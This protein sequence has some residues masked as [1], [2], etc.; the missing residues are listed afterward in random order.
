M[1]F[2]KPKDISQYY[3]F[4]T[5]V[6][7]LTAAAAGIMWTLFFLKQPGAHGWGD[8]LLWAV[9]FTVLL[10]LAVYWQQRLYRRHTRKVL[11]MLDAIENNDTAIHFSETDGTED[12]R[13]VN[14]SL[15]RVAR[16]LHNVK[17][18]TAQ[19]EKYYELILDC[20]NTGIIVL[21]DNGAVYQKNNE[22]LRLLGLEV[23]THVR[24]LSRVDAHLT[25]TLTA[26]RP[27][28]KFQAAFGNE[29]G[30]VNLSVRVSDITVRQEHL[31]IL[32]LN[33]INNELDEKEIDSWIR[34]TRVL[35]HEIMNAV[36][37]ITS[38]SDTLLKLTE[39]RISKEEMRHG[40][41]TIS[42][43]GKGLLAFV[44]SYR[45]FTRIPTPE[46]S[47]F[48]LKG[49]INRMAELARHQYPDTPVTFN[50][51]I[52][53]DD[54]ILYADEN[55]I[56]QVII[57]LLK[58]P[59]RLLKR[60]P[61][62]Q[63]GQMRKQQRKQTQRLRKTHQHTRLLQ[64]SRSRT[65]RNIQQRPCHP[66]GHCRAYFHSFLHHQ[67]KRK[68]HRTEHLPANHALIRRKPLSDSREGDNFCIEI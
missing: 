62:Q 49:F 38:L 55:L 4:R 34:L 36:T 5:V 45:R 35:T 56:S 41:Q 31:R 23:F 65:D 12:N 22:A 63:R 17:S 21:N 57:N 53:P 61:R 1:G 6:S 14:R 58:M 7:L 39:A 37:P 50:V 24:Q 48:Y 19:R 46:P 42:T 26:C 32:A 9:L 15:N 51:S 44:E 64:R 10:P 54:L 43:T 67:R 30:T 25:D 20:V 3:V 11:F 2:E 52:V 60:V 29:R 47:L 13:L 66:P 16:I 8:P 59:Y 33:D 27:G 68:R 40:L 28:D 18:E